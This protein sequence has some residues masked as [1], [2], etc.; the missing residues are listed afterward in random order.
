MKKEIWLAIFG[1]F[2]GVVFAAVYDYFK[3]LPWLYTLK[4]IINYLRINFL[5]VKIMVWQILFVIIVINVSL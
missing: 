5:E 4:S 2:L 3:E 1:A